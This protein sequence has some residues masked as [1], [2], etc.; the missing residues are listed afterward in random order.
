VSLPQLEFLTIVAQPVHSILLDHLLIPTDLSLSQCFNFSDDKSPIPAYLPK[1]L[2]NLQ[3]V[4][5]ITSINLS[6]DPGMFLRIEG[7]SGSHYMFGNWCGVGLSP[8]IVDARVIQSLTL[9]RISTV[10]RLA[11]TEY[12]ASAPTKTEKSPVY[13]MLLLMSNLRTLTLTDCLILPFLFALNPNRNS[14]RAVVCPKLE[15]IVL[16]IMNKDK[17]WPCVDELLEAMKERAS[18]GSKLPAITIVCPEEFVPAK[19]VFKLKDYVSRV[20]YRLDDVAPGWDTI[21]DDVG[22][23][24]YE[25]DW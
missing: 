10:E 20:E 6:F 16:Y 24:G 22:Y 18:R 25:S 14:S 23:T 15:E 11:I 5:R 4:S 7:P 8:S 2:E 19:Q 12:S 3:N 13:P 17:D 21:P 1:K 9:F